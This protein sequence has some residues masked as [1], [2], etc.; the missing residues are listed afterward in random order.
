[1]SEGIRYDYAMDGITPHKELLGAASL[2]LNYVRLRRHRPPAHYAPN[3][4]H[5]Q[6]SR[7]QRIASGGGVMLSLLVSAHLRIGWVC[8]DSEQRR[9]SQVLHPA[10]PNA[11]PRLVRRDGPKTRGPALLR[12][13]PCRLPSSP[14]TH[15]CVCPCGQRHSSVLA[16]GVSSGAPILRGEG[17]RGAHINSSSA[18]GMLCRG[19]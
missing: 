1:V 9:P 6:C 17:V 12:P 10:A 14:R 2:P 18:A 15:A 3:S 13:N 5:S 16:A 11:A 4:L 8:A 19:G 7:V